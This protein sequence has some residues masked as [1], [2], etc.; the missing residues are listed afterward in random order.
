MNDRQ[1]D[2]T[3]LVLTGGTIGSRLSTDT[4]TLSTG[5]V[6][7]IP[8]AELLSAAWNGDYP[9][10]EENLH[11]IRPLRRLSE[12]IVPADWITIAHEIEKVLR[13]DEHVRRILVL[14]G[15]DTATYTAA[16]LSFLLSHAP[17]PIVLTG[18]NHPSN[19][20]QSDAT[21]NLRGAVA[22][23]R[24][25]PPGTYLS[26]SGVPGAPSVVHLGTRVR[27]LRASGQAFFS[28]NRDEVAYV[29]DQTFVPHTLPTPDEQPHP[30]VSPKM[31]VDDSVSYVKVFPGCDLA[32]LADMVIDSGQHGVVV[33]LYPSATGPTLGK[34]ESLPRF[35]QSC[36]R[37]NVVVVGCVAEAPRHGQSMDLYEST[38]AIRGAGAH[39][40]PD[41]LPETAVVK[42]MWALA[43][44]ADPSAVGDLMARPVAGEVSSGSRN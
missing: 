12:D 16:A 42:L 14:H 34:R 21:T 10:N 44:A 39:F 29:N 33:E 31:A 9:F 7:G 28:I 30:L 5:D 24:H 43:Q 32:A 4:V 15:T 1:D 41:L 3:A 38:H 23:L 35:I 40:F 20:P 26:F 17:V 8:E 25:L 27:K 2:R 11:V 22:A 6:H 37:A 19:H 13:R 18:A 36:V